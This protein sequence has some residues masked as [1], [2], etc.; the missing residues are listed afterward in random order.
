M[1]FFNSFIYKWQTLIGA[2]L[3]PF[4][5]VVLSAIGYL[6]GAKYKTYKERREAIRRTEV[7]LTISL[8]DMYTT[9]EKLEDFI[10]RL[11]DLVSRIRSI[12]DNTTYSLEE[13]NFPSIKD[14]FAEKDFSYFKFKSYYLHNKLL[15]SNSGI[16]ATNNILKGLKDDFRTMIKKSELLTAM[17]A[18]PRDQRITYAE[19]L[20][21]FA[22]AVE[23]FL[24]YI[25][26]G[27]KILTQSKI[28]NL[29]LLEKKKPFIWK[30]EGVAFKYFGNKEEISKYC[31][32]LNC[33]DRIDRV[34]EE[35][36][37]NA[38]TEAEERHRQNMQ[39]A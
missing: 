9:R 31:K 12:N 19:N 23:G 33:L 25:N 24:P 10:S 7:A 8:N 5:A 37:N 4:L 15:A 30:H 2:A 29:K 16:E 20:E 22:N 28:Y 1:D 13:I 17:K 26:E 6:I 11:R 36:V 34:I 39:N 18:R 21:N 32:H 27:I 14:I 35:E 3:G 38:I